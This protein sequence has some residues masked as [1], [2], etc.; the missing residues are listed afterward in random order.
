MTDWRGLWHR[1]RERFEAYSLRERALLVLCLLAVV[2]GFWQYLVDIPLA[3]QRANLVNEQENIASQREGLQAQKTALLS[4]DN[5][6]GA[7]EELAA[8]QRRRDELDERLASLSQG[9]VSAQQL[10]ELLQQVL[11]S[12]TELR[13]ERVR[14]L[15][16]SELS[17]AAPAPESSGETQAVREVEE[18]DG[19]D[20]TTG[21]Y[22]HTVE[23]EVS[24]DFFEVYAFVQRLESLS[25]RFYWE[26]LDY[27]VADY[28]M[29]T[30][31]LRVYTLSAEEGLLGV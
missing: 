7:S 4:A 10:P 13:L 29:A 30:V 3:Q 8:L 19:P 6:A 15:P 26:R 14:T 23:L 16:V 5:G 22:R 28:P 12:T 25:W 27:R 1:G 20:K 24:G 17:L 9:L 2:I 31:R 18:G 11:V 21:V